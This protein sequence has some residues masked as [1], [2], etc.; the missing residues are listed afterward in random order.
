MNKTN[1][2]TLLYLR[3]EGESAPNPIEN[4]NE[5]TALAKR[6]GLRFKTLNYRNVTG[7]QIDMP[8]L[9]SQI[10]SA[11]GFWVNNPGLLTDDAIQPAVNARLLEGAIMFTTLTSQYRKGDEYFQELGIESTAIR[12][13]AQPK[14]KSCVEA[15]D[16]LVSLNRDFY[17]FGFRDYVLFKGV[18]ELWLKH[19]YGIGCFGGA[20][21]ILALPSS[22]IRLLDTNKDLYVSSLPRPEFPVMATTGMED[23]RGRIIA[24]NVDFIHD[25]YTGLGGRVFPCI[26]GADNAR[27]A[28]NLIQVISDGVSPPGITWE[29]AFLL[30]D[31]TETAIYRITERILRAHQGDDWFLQMT[32]IATRDKC[33][34]RAQDERGGFP[35]SAYLDLIDFKLIWKTNW[36]FFGNLF[37]STS[38][39]PSKGAS[40]KF[41]QELNEIRKKIAHPTKRY[42]SGE[43]AP[44]SDQLK[45]LR[46]CRHHVKLFDIKAALPRSLA[47]APNM[48]TWFK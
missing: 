17:E 42:H 37:T 43:S 3:L 34:K 33:L 22:E 20:K 30:L 11:H 32:P 35:P 2:K 39:A 45:Q 10:E 27:L 25:A 16:S 6:A 14:S 5:V 13:C 48:L 19:P 1:M 8:H 7:N 40:L 21:P 31:E 38:E 26:E 47:A 24:A 12:A 41:L 28:K 4:L 9:M 23:W 44:S 36:N 15:D 18:E 29:D 46:E